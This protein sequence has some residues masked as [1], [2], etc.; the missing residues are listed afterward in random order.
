L[1]EYGDIKFNDE[2][3]RLDNFAIELQNN[4]GSTGFIVVYGGCTGQGQ[5]RGERAR[6]YLVN[7]RGIGADRIQIIDGGCRE[8]LSVELYVCPAGSQPPAATPTVTPCPDC[9]VRPRSR[10]T[11]RTAP[12]RRRG[13]RDDE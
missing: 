12:R 4:P 3:A 7:T 11:R 1:D 2:K 9:K 8:A 5:A 13:G 10:G 6:D